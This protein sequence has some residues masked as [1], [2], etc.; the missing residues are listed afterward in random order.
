MA[1]PEEPGPCLTRGVEG[2]Q[3]PGPSVRSALL[4]KDSPGMEGRLRHRRHQQQPHQVRFKDLEEGSSS[5]KT[6]CASGPQQSGANPARQSWPQAKRCL[7][8]L[9]SCPKRCASTAIQT[10]PGLQRPSEG[11]PFPS[12]SACTFAHLVGHPPGV[13]DQDLPPWGST[14]LSEH[15]R[16]PASPQAQAG[17]CPPATGGPVYPLLVRPLP[18]GAGHA[19]LQA[20]PQRPAQDLLPLVAVRQAQQP[21]PSKAAQ[22]PSPQE[23]GDLRSRLQSL[24][25]V[26]EA[27]QEAI[28][29]LLGVIQDLEKKEARR[30]GRQSY[31]TGQDL[32]NC[33]MC[34]DC[35][36]VIYS[37]EHDFRQQEGRFQQ[38]LSTTELEPGQRTPTAGPAATLSHHKLLPDPGPPVK[39]GPKK[40]RRRCFWFL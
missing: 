18:S 15:N 40:S 1:S 10:S 20:E 22:P 25:G 38:V 2:G 36:C 11:G 3:P 29:V 4:R 9:P 17:P 34:Q 14:S 30:D 8:P 19:P 24:E 6:P 7:L 33:R 26:L 39:A 35:A 16:H 12:R 37:V 23:T 28:R 27:R 13:L 32:A 31:R 21:D 5:D